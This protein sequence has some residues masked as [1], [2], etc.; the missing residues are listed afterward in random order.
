MKVFVQGLW[1]RA[2]RRM[3]VSGLLALVLLVPTVAIAIWLPQLKERNDALKDAVANQR[4]VLAQRQAHSEPPPRPKSDYEKSTEFVAGLPTLQQSSRD[5]GK[6]FILAMRNNVA[7]PKGEYQVRQDSN[8]AL[9]AYTVTFPVNS[10]YSKLKA[11]VASVLD[12][13]PHAAMD[14]L[15]MSR[16]DAGSAML[17]ATVRFTFL[18]RR[19]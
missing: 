11:F 8:A 6:V 5:L 18:Y 15:R 3:G 14:E 13:L 4:A 19:Q 17:D 10:D 9:L 16:P 2:V 7:L 12:A 1:Q